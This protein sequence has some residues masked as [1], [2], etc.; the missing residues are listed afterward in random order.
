MREINLRKVI[1]L[2]R[3]KYKLVLCYLKCKSC[4]EVKIFLRV[5]EM[6]LEY[7]LFDVVI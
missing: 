7:K 3:V 4:G 5:N 2:V 6:E 1:K